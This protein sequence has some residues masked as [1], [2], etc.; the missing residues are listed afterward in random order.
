M[1]N[2]YFQEELTLLKDLGAAFSKAHPAVAPMLS[3]PSADPDV[4]RLLEGVAFLTALLRQKIDDDFPEIT[5]DLTRLIWPHYLRPIPSTTMIAVSPKPGLK[6][7]VSIPAGIQV[8]SLPI[9]GTSCLFRTIYDVDLHP[10]G[11]LDARLDQPSGSPPAITL[12]LELRDL[13]VSGWQPKRLRF[14]LAGDFMNAADIYFVLHTHVKRIIIRSA[15][16]GHRC[17][18][19]PDFLKPVGFSDDEALIPWPNQAFSGYRVL[20]EYFIAPQKFLFFDLLGWENWIFRGDD[21]RFEIRFELDD[22]PEPPPRVHRESFALSVTPAINIF[23]HDAD[24]VL[25]DQK[26][27]EYMIRPAGLNPE[28]YQVYSIE[29]V[30]GYVQGTAEE[31]LYVPFEFFNPDA[32]SRPVYHIGQKQSPLHAGFDVHLSV[33]YPPDA[34][35]PPLAETL[36][37]NILSTNG[38]LPERLQVGDICLPTSSSPE[39]AEYKN[40]QPVTACIQPPLGTNLLWR[41]LS[42]LSLNYLSLERTENLKALL[43]LYVFPESHDQLTIMANRKRI[44]G[45][46]QIEAKP[47]HRLISGALM[48]GLE[49]VLRIRQDHFAGQGDLYLFGSVL[50]HFLGGYT[51]INSYT[52]TSIHEVTKGRLY[53]WPARLGTRHLL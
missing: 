1:F 17:M 21:S 39:F 10:L 31:R 19:T 46:Q 33:A 42:H 30:T 2:R 51:S 24:P 37:I 5:H 53:S 29:R 25:L 20:Q 13:R 18:L 15:G 38:S 23:T 22:I 28:H 40:I 44:E 49:I 16:K 43:K 50:D 7:S 12:L 35:P 6:Q 26:K 8:A 3:G 14:F 34:G 4:E 32:Q 36:S 52:R 27:T 41:L 9:E 48:R 47:S 11:I 45:I